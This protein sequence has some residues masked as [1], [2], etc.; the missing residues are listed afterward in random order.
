[1][2]ALREK[3]RECN[4]ELGVMRRQMAFF[5]GLYHI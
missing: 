3:S 1:M 4:N 5:Q 2:K